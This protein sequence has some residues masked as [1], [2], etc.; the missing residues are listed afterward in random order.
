MNIIR[1]IIIIA[2]GLMLA[3]VSLDFVRE[4]IINGFSFF[5][6]LNIILITINI[7][8]FLKMEKKWFVAAMISGLV[9]L[10]M[11]IELTIES[12][13]MYSISITVIV[14][15]LCYLMLAL[16]KRYNMKIRP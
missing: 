9:L 13:K 5:P 3:S 14:A 8:A 4:T 2:L 7:I 10:G 16:F 11:N 6:I 12:L 1:W 15:T